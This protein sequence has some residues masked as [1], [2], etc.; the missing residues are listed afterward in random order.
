[1]YFKYCPVFANRVGFNQTLDEYLC[2][3]RITILLTLS[4]SFFGCSEEIIE[5]EVDSAPKLSVVEEQK[6]EAQ[7]EQNRIKANSDKILADAQKE[8]ELSQITSPMTPNAYPET[9]QIWGNEWMNQINALL[10]PAAKLVSTQPECNKVA[11]VGLSE[12]KSIARVDPV[13]FIDCENNL[14][15]FLDAEDI[16]EGKV[17]QPRKSSY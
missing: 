8:Y 10:L 4:I 11:Y 15:Y 6:I 3:K 5:P 12:D 17:S 13:L 16:N 14:R 2:M 9:Y 1:M 7:Q